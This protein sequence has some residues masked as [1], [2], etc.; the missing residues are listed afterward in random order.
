MCKQLPKTVN[1]S[2]NAFFQVFEGNTDTVTA[3][4]TVLDPPITA[5]QARRKTKLYP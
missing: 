5:R 4:L 2:R 1:S 3:E